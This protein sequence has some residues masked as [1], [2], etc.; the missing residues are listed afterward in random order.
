V[1]SLG[2]RLSLSFV[3][4]RAA[5]PV[6]QFYRACIEASFAELEQTVLGAGASRGTRSRASA[7]SGGRGVRAGRAVRRTGNSGARAGRVVGVA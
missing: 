5:M 3:A 4:D 2:G 1:F 6:P 7:R